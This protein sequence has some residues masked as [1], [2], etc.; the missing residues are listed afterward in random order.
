ME[1][2]YYVVRRSD[3][4]LSHAQ[5]GKERAGHKYVKREWKNNRWQYWYKDDQGNLTTNKPTA[6]ANAN[7]NTQLSPSAPK[8]GFAQ[9]FEKG[10]ASISNLFT[11]TVPLPAPVTDAPVSRR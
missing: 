10:K 6:S 3:D 2:Q 9:L 11:K 4:T 5:K 1:K 7:I 8:S